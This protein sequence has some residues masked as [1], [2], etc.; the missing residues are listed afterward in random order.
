MTVLHVPCLLE[1]GEREGDQGASIL[2]FVSKELVK[3]AGESWRNEAGFVLPARWITRERE[4]ETERQSE[5][6]RH[7]AGGGT[8]QSAGSLISGFVPPALGLHP[9]PHPR[10]RV[11]QRRP[12]VHLNPD[13]YKSQFPHKAV[14]LSCII[15]NIKNKL[16]DL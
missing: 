15:P 6:D 14:N 8:D 1:S 9:E 11:V 3:R 4:T 7:R 12:R 10:D 16:T 2:I 5:R 13:Y